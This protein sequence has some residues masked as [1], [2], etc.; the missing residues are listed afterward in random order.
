MHQ[1]THIHT[2]AY[3]NH[4]FLILSRSITLNVSAGQRAIAPAE[5]THTHTFKY[6]THVVV[7]VQ[8][9]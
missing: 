5:H 2:R 9:N 3:T 1:Y 8:I 4:I 7:G 6:A